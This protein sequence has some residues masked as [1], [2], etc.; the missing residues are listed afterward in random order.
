MIS[1][2]NWKVKRRVLWLALDSCHP[3]ASTGSPRPGGPLF[4]RVRKFDGYWYA[5]VVR[6]VC[7]PPVQLSSACLTDAKSQQFVGRPHF[8]F[9][10]VGSCGANHTFS[11]TRILDLGH[12]FGQ[13]RSNINRVASPL[14]SNC[15]G[16]H[17][18]HVKA[19]ARLL[20][21]YRSL[22]KESDNQELRLSLVNPDSMMHWH[23]ILQGPPDTPFAGGVFELDLR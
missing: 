22:E 5:L 6:G 10:L 4:V 11:A 15:N 7:G 19:A 18:S 16:V 3:V 2:T 9:R 20:K 21:E 8:N 14:F 1:I 17:A 13:A 23:C 12:T